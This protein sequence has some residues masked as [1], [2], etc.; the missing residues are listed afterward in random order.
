MAGVILRKRERR[1]PQFALRRPINGLPAIC[2]L[3]NTHDRRLSGIVN[4]GLSTSQH[5]NF[6]FETP[7]ENF[8]TA[9][10]QDGEDVVSQPNLGR[11]PCPLNDLNQITQLSGRAYSYDDNGNLLR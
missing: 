11:R 1:W 7:P 4:T 2:Y 8:I 6:T 9:I 10:K 3:D 5:T